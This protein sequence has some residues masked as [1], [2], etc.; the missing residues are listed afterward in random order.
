[1]TISELQ[2]G[3][4]SMA[5]RYPAVMSQRGLPVVV[6]VL[7]LGASACPPPD[8]VCGDGVVEAG[9]DEST[10][11]E[12]TGC[13]FGA[14]NA[15]T[16]ACEDPWAD[17]C[18][19]LE[20]CLFDGPYVCRDLEP[21][22][23]DCGTCGCPGD[24]RCEGGACF[25]VQDLAGVRDDADIPPDLPIDEYFAFIDE[26]S[27]APLT[28]GE[29]AE[30]IALRTRADRRASAVVIGSIR[31]SPDELAAATKLTQALVAQGLPAAETEL[32]AAVDACDLVAPIADDSTADERVDVLVV[33]ADVA[34]R[35][36][37]AR[38]AMFPACALPTA[39]DC[40]LSAG[41][42]PAT[43]MLIDH[44][45][46]LARVD[47]VLLGRAANNPPGEVLFQLDLVINRWRQSVDTLGTPAAH[48][49]EL[50]SGERY[51]RGDFARDD[52][53]MWWLALVGRGAS[54]W[55]LLGYRA[56]WNDSVTQAFLTDNDLTGRDCT[57]EVAEPEMAYTC[58]DGTA[59]IE[60]TIDTDTLAILDVT[61]TP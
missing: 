15:A 3:A 1:M 46:L 50:A 31:T 10:C 9:E 53:A 23:Y 59:R 8:P 6:V 16:S 11:C 60:A 13:S 52:P 41:R 7:A 55:G 25:T 12:D 30:A 32:A 40:L 44:V 26:L 24:E 37:C 45:A 4:T 42:R 20:E 36:V 49:V 54:P 33:P 27:R 47:R 5:W 29:V 17:D 19:G 43:V 39:S 22:G 56:L 34:H 14:C 51:L 35:E 58:D 2:A 21:P 48:A 28:L 18:A 57:W 38:Q 61:T